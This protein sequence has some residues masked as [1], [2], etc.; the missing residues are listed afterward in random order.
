MASQPIHAAAL[1]MSMPMTTEVLK[2]TTR[3]W[4]KQ[5]VGANLKDVKAYQLLAYLQGAGQEGIAGFYAFEQSLR[6]QYAEKQKGEFSTVMRDVIFELAPKECK[7]TYV[8]IV[9]E[10]VF[11]PNRAEHWGTQVDVAAYSDGVGLKALS[12]RMFY[13]PCLNT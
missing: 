2:N 3:D 1:A 11:T 7:E 9:E 10:V 13:Q 5:Q 8:K 6:G 12:K 4:L